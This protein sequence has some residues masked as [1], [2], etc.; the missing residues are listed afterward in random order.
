MVLIYSLG[1]VQSMTNRSQSYPDGWTSFYH[2]EIEIKKHLLQWLCYFFLFLFFIWIELMVIMLYF[3]FLIGMNFLMI[4]QIKR[5][6]RK[7]RICN[8]AN[9]SLTL[10]TDLFYVYYWRGCITMQ[11]TINAAMS[12]KGTPY[13]MAPEVILQTG[14][15]L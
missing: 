14:H 10:V 15:S 12:M 9:I 2:L 5:V 1:V 11:A 3:L 6:I 13:W 4:W 8:L 7:S